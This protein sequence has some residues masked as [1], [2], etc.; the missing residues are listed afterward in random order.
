MLL[1]EP[2]KLIILHL[3][4]NDLTTLSIWQLHNVISR[5]VGYLRAAFPNIKFVWV[6]ILQRQVWRGGLCQG[7]IETKR[8]RINRLGRKLVKKTGPY[9]FLSVDI[10][11]G[12][13]FFRDDGVHL[14]QVG[15]EFYLDSLQDAILECI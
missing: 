3:G 4:G 6:D 10:K 11:A 14:N 9:K 15:L 7:A 2:P 1:E 12:E 8:V 13:G 5:E